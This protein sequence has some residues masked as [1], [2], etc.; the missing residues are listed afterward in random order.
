ME[1]RLRKQAQA[2]AYAS[3]M[4]LAQQ[5]LAAGNPSRAR[6]LLE[7]HWKPGQLERPGWEWRYLWQQCQSDGF[8]LLQTGDWIVSMAVSHDGK[9]LAVGD[10]WDEKISLLDISDIRAPREIM[11]FRGGTGPSFAFSPTSPLLALTKAGPSRSMSVQVLNVETLRTVVRLPL[12]T[13]IAF[14][15][16][17]RDG[18]TLLTWAI[19][20]TKESESLVTFWRVSDGLGRRKSIGQ[21]TRRGSPD[22]VPARCGHG[23]RPQRTTDPAAR[24]G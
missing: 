12:S 4:N 17:S 1:A 22:A 19:D 6:E 21:L 23:Q 18:R 3:D 7:N 20:Q 9:W 2:H 24:S 15:T 10:I 8:E 16:F 14:L 13:D 5:A 11:S